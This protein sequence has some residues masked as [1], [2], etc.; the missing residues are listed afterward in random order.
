MTPEELEEINQFTSTP[1]FQ[2][3]RMQAVQNPAIIP[4]IL[5]LI[6][7]SNPNIGRVLMDNRPLIAH[8]LIHGSMNGVQEHTS[9]EGHPIQEEVQGSDETNQ[10][11]V[12]VQPT[13]Q[14][15]IELSEDD[16]T[17]INT[18]VEMGFS[19]QQAIEA[20]LVCNKNL[21]LAIN[22]LFDQQ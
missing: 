2:Q 22:Y 5:L 11:N 13:M 8:L 6:N 19:E 16:H 21:E 4:Q 17:N 1:V 12:P 3:L 15:T 7:Q 10:P 18:I 14:P 9:E 20:F